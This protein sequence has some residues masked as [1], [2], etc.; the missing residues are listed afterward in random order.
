MLRDVKQKTNHKAKE[1]QVNYGRSGV[2]EQALEKFMTL[3]MGKIVVSKED[4]STADPLANMGSALDHI[5]QLNTGHHCLR[6]Y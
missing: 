5:V 6:S 2:V 3:K 4:G 1:K